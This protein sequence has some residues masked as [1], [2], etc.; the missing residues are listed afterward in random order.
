MSTPFKHL[1]GFSIRGS[2]NPRWYGRDRTPV[3]GQ[4]KLQRKDQWQEKVLQ[5][6]FCQ[7]RKSHK[8]RKGL[9]L[10]GTAQYVK[11]RW[12]FMIEEHPLKTQDKYIKINQKGASP[13]LTLHPKVG[14]SSKEVGE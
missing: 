4:R 10:S 5:C 2:L 11:K 6:C 8:K 14:I 1:N 3:R 13:S 7:G 9:T 12:T